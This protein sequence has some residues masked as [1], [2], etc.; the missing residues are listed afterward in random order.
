MAL[1]IMQKNLD[2][3]GYIEIPGLGVRIEGNTMKT[4]GQVAFD[5]YRKKAGSLAYDGTEIPAWDNLSPSIQWYWK[6]AGEAAQ[7]FDKEGLRNRTEV[8][9][10]LEG[11]AVLF[12]NADLADEDSVRLHVRARELL[13]VLRQDL[14]SVQ[15]IALFN[16][17]VAEVKERKD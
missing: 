2:E 17:M 13:W 14:D 10:R 6:A 11:L 16:Q 15:Q 1:A 9:L 4:V 12:A 5:A 3:G 8:V 7:A